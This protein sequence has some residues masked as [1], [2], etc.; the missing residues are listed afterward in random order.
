MHRGSVLSDTTSVLPFCVRSQQW[1][2]VSVPTHHL[3]LLVLVG[4]RGR[5]EAWAPTESP[6]RGKTPRDHWPAR[7]IKG[8]HLE[9]LISLQR[10]SFFK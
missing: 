2:E 8:Q 7:E 9:K 6:Q 4:Y 3:V 10:G 5:S 1:I